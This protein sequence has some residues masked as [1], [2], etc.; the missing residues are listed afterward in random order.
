MLG[1]IKHIIT[2]NSHFPSP[3]WATKASD[4]TLN[5]MYVSILLF[6]IMDSVYW[7]LGFADL[8][9]QMSFYVWK[10]PEPHRGNQFKIFRV[11]LLRNIYCH[12]ALWSG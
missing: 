6:Q 11:F 4:S 10:Y 12:V 8:D 3:C 2:I 1:Y 7:C 5:K 9:N